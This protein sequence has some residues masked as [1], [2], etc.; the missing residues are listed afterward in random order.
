MATLLS[1]DHVKNYHPNYQSWRNM[2]GSDANIDSFVANYVVPFADRYKNNPYVWSA[3]LM[4]EPDWA[5][6]ESGIAWARLQTLFAKMSVGVHANSN[7]LTTVGVAMVKYNGD[8]C[9]PNQG[10]QGNKVGDSVLMSKVSNNPQAKL[11]YWSVHYYDW[12]GQY[13]GVPMYMSPAQYGMSADRPNILG[14]STAKGTVGHTLTDDI[15]NAYANGWQGIMPWTSNGVDA[16]GN[17]SD[18]A[19]AASAFYALH[20]GLVFP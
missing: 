2:V 14:E 9:D 13:W 5:F 15:M 17:M 3:D 7:M 20:P 19:P 1:F 12:M 4:N 6:E 11:D 16:N 10:C 8:T 18:L